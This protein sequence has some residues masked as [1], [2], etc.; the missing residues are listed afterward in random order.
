L[1][2]VKVDADDTFVL[3]ST[4]PPPADP[5]LLFFNWKGEFLKNLIGA[6]YLKGEETTVH[7][8]PEGKVYVSVMRNDRRPSGGEAVAEVRAGRTVEV[9]APFVAV[10]GAKP[11]PRLAPL[12]EQMKRQGERA[13]GDALARALGVE[14][15]RE[16]D[17]QEQLKHLFSIP[18]DKK[19][20]LPGG[21]EATVGDILSASAYLQL[22]EEEARRRPRGPQPPTQPAK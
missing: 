10:R 15:G 21:G 9:H 12:Y 7:G 17:S 3:L 14:Q 16:M 8:V 6:Q 1:L 5:V 22:E 20:A 11:P 18:F 13:F 2:R 4:R 19:V